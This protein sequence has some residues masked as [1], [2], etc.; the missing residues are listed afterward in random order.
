MSIVVMN[1]VEQLSI[2]VKLQVQIV[3]RTVKAF[4]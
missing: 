1:I 3:L 4:L 2:N